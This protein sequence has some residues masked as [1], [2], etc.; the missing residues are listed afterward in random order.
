MSDLLQQIRNL[1]AQISSNHLNTQAQLELY[2]A[3]SREA[4]RALGN[5]MQLAFQRYGDETQRA[6]Q[7]YGDETHGAL[8]RYELRSD[9]KTE[10]A[11]ATLSEQ[12]QQT[13]T[14]LTL[15]AGALESYWQELTQERELY[16][17]RLEDLEH[18]IERVRDHE[19]RLLH[20]EQGRSAA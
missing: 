19:T 4:V 3:E 18:V 8:Q 16:Q 20:L 7:R 12:Q 10:G 9:A 6:L 13:S 11:V 1:K 15:V 5:E 2:R 14:S 17:N